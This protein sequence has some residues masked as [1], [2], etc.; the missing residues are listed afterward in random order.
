MRI[1][2]VTM[3]LIVSVLCFIGSLKLFLM[4]SFFI[5]NKWDKFIGVEFSNNSLL[6]LA[7]SLL[8]LGF[9]SLA[10]ALSWISGKVYLPSTVRV[11]KNYQGMLLARYWYLIMPA[12][13]CLVAAVL[14]ATEVPNPNHTSISLESLIT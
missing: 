8:L 13:I 11:D 14:M 9:F 1:L 2:R 7:L 5:A 4:D 3:N 12:M 10:I 6:L